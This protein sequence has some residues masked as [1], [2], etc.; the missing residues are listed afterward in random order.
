MAAEISTTL[1]EPDPPRS[2]L[3]QRHALEPRAAGWRAAIIRLRTADRTATGFVEFIAPSYPGPFMRWRGVGSKRGLDRPHS[4]SV[5]RSSNA[6]FLLRAFRSWTARDHTGRPA[7]P[8]R[9]HHPNSFC[10]DAVADLIGAARSRHSQPP[11][12]ASTLAA[13]IASIVAPP[14]LRP[15]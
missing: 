9:D 2:G 11:F 4:L 13:I 10:C 7:T 5:I 1:R 15:G 12:M 14:F 8:P 3:V 6:P